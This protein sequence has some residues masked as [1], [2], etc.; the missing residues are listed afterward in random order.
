MLDLYYTQEGP[1]ENDTAALCRRL[2]LD[3]KKHGAVLGGLLGEFFGLNAHQ[4]LWFHCRCDAEIAKYQSKADANRKNGKA[5][6]RPKQ[7]EQE[8]KNNPSGYQE[9][10]ETETQNN[11]NQNQN[12]NQLNPLSGKPDVPL[13]PPKNNPASEAEKKRRAEAREVAIRMIDY[14]NDKAGTK[15]MHVETNIGFPLAR[16]FYDGIS[17]ETLRAVV[18]AKAEEVRAG[19]FDAKYFRPATLFNAEKCAQYVGQLSTVPDWQKGVL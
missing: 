6:G 10:T 9:V 19:K 18:D 8:P 2:R 3:H 5:G 13:A 12:Q 14:L 1:L 7:T 16:V 15:F 11:L 4:T 17:E